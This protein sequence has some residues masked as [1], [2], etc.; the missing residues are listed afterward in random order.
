MKVRLC[1]LLAT[2]GWVT[3]FDGKTLQGWVNEGGA[4][5]RVEQGVITVDHGPYTWLRSEKSYRD[6]ELVV[7]F[8]TAA[9]GN[10]GIFLR[11]AATGKPHETGYEVQIFDG[12]KDY[13]TGGV[14]GHAKGASGVKLKPDVWNTYEVK[15]QGKR[16]V[17]KLNGKEVLDWSDDKATAGHIGLQFNP[18]KPISFRNIK[19]REL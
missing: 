16:M 5:F 12:H 2:G 13:P 17:V 3:L 14:V 6:Y 8:K 10:S 7:E 1:L 18:N 4:N 9:D 19:I 11:S 15:H